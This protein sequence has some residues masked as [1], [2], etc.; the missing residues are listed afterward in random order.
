[1]SLQDLARPGLVTTGPLFEVRN[2]YNPE[3]R[4]AVLVVPGLIGVILTP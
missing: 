3:R 1:M 2:F 4:S